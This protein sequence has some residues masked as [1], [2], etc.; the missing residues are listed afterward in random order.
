M[1]EYPSGT[2]AFLFTDIEGSTK[3]WETD[4]Q[5]MSAAVDRHI[6]LLRAAIAAQDGVHFKTIGDAVQAAFPTVP[7]AIAAAIDAQ[8][9]LRRADWGEFGP[10]RVRMAIHAGDATPRDGDYLA[11]A[12]NRLSRVLGTGYGEQILLTD[13][14]RTL[15]TTL[16]VGFA[17]QDLGRHRLRDLL[18]AERIYQLCGPG[19][20]ATFPPL[21]S[22]DQQPHNL[23]AQP[24]ALVGREDELATLRE[25]LAAPETRLVTLTG[26]GGTGKTRLALQ[27][28]AESLDTFP[29]GVWLVP[30][31]TVSDPALVPEAIATALGV[32]QAP[33][34]HVLA[35]LTEHLRS[36]HM[37]LVLDNLEQVVDAAPMIGQLIE[38]A[39]RLVVLATSRE[40]L[41]L[42]AERELPIPPLPVPKERPRLSPTE[43]L[44]SP[45]VRLFV[46]R[47]HAV[48]PG[49]ALDASNVAEVVAICR[50]LD[51]LPLAIE[52]AAARVRILTPAALLARL[53]QRLAI[54][55]GGARDL[56]ARQQ[57]LRA[58]IAWSNDLLEP[59][60]Q[61][62]FARLGVF[63]GGCSFEAA[64]AIC[65]AAG[66]IEIDLFDGIAS[67][68]QKSLLRQVEG[69]AGEARFTML[70]T[71]LEF[72]QE[73]LRQL[74]E[75]TELRRVHAETF[76][77][78]AETADWDD[79]S[80]EADILDRLEAD[81][82]NFRTAIETYHVQ[83]ADGAAERL[84]LAG[85]LAYFWWVRGHLTEGRQMIDRA[86]EAPGA[87]DPHI[88]AGAL[89]GA[90][91]LA[92][93]QGD[94][95][96]AESLH[97]EALELS[98]QAGDANGIARA[99]SDLGMIA[100]QRGD[101]EIAR[102]RH[103]E[104]LEAWRS[105][106][107]AAGVA[108]AILDL[109]GIRLLAGDYTGAEP[110]L[111]ES[112]R[113]F[114]QL[115]DASGEASALQT[116]GVLASATGDFATAIGRFEKSLSLW[117]GLSNQQMIATDLA[118]LGEAHHLNGA[119]DDAESLYRE[120]LALLEA[121]GDLGGQGYVCSQLGLLALDRGNA[122]DARER[123]IEGLRLRWNAGER[124]AAADTLEALAE[125]FR[126]LGDTDLS[127]KVLQAAI[128]LRRET[129]IARPPVY[130]RRYQEM[131]QALADS[132]QPNLPPD[133]EAVVASLLQSGIAPAT[134]L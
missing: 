36:R 85:A 61:T 71:I 16:P 108:T 123:L 42:R 78:L 54:L 96:R 126:R 66:G 97:A 59:P 26:A 98:R 84:R 34:E 60:E 125:A 124:G 6:A 53:D 109:A 101:L 102:S 93:S 18:E 11:P 39:P 74:P 41:R 130:D 29:D 112:L 99:L 90:A 81:H 104:A 89:S 21:K 70:Q 121:I 119:L 8:V 40:P 62:L 28:A 75:A 91:L 122:S 2:V 13:T 3:R 5:V 15:A 87:G 118:N 35:R 19:L 4:Q 120:A 83:G 77:A 1:P 105:A 88:R 57:T 9:A 45:A 86:L 14:A 69:A 113:L 55:T 92:E 117:R 44:A 23:P 114:Q 12:L 67:L 51:G 25:M 49:F 46:E 50:R 80:R 111:L 58:T 103:R 107:D 106:G 10:L 129:G 72:A 30:L 82:P 134:K 110:E 94:L 115:D 128:A 133:V 73:R 132:N 43:A 37:L 56:P 24:T 116:L 20:P 7:K 95:G 65:S 76:L 17:L 27:A 48:K 127:A 31:A 52:L 131:L 47:A 68:V 79:P 63:A 22:L 38:E 100:R 64:E 33:G 32:R